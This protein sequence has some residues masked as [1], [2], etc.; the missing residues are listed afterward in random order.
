MKIITNDLYSEYTKTIVTQQSIL[1]DLT[2]E[3]L[4]D[5]FKFHC[6][7][8]KILSELVDYIYNL[9][10]KDKSIKQRSITLDD[11][12]IRDVF[13][14]RDGREYMVTCSYG[15]HERLSELVTGDWLAGGWLGL[16]NY[17]ENLTYDGKDRKFDIVEVYKPRYEKVWIRGKEV[18][19][20][21]TVDEISKEL[22]YTVEVVPIKERVKSK[23][24]IK[25]EDL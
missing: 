11:L 17:K 14:I 24:R 5:M 20:E 15:A 22:G 6:Q 18:A 4:Y 19:Q 9:I 21:M 12:K 1:K 16:G 10:Q 13:K 3:K 25:R 8:A 23:S 7:D 2:K